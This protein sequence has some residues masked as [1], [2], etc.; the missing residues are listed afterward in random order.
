MRHIL[1]MLLGLAGLA[2]AQAPSQPRPDNCEAIRL[3]IE[4][5]M[6][7]GGVASPTLLVRPADAGGAGR[8]VGTCGN[9]TLQ[10]VYLGGLSMQ[11]AAAMAGRVAPAVA[12]RTTAP[13]TP[14]ATPPTT[15]SATA[16]L[17]GPADRIP[18]ECKD[19]SIVIGPRCD[20]P[21]AVRM[22]AAEL[23]APAA[24][25]PTPPAS[26]PA[27]SAAASQAAKPASS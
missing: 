6:R 1:P 4:Q 17:A 14:P 21:R 12:L 24:A 19:G 16:S 23:A 18:T 5:R 3:Q 26:A 20:D 11:P 2:H 9:S 10:I 7:A 27:A 8:V 25:A 13:A 15:P 22:T